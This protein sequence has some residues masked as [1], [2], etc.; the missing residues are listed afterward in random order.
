MKK[1]IFLI[2]AAILIF[3][4]AVKSIFQIQMLVKIVIGVLIVCLFLYRQLKPHK[5]ML[6]PKYQKWFS[7]IEALYDWLF[8]LLNLAPVKLGNTLSIDITSLLL[9]VLF[10]ILLIL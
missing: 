7:G 10:I 4:F 1:D 5:D 2:A 8:K 6:Y 3:I 9:L